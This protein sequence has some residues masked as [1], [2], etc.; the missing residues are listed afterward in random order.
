ME[1]REVLFTCPL[2]KRQGRVLVVLPLKRFSIPHLDLLFSRCPFCQRRI[3]ETRV[4]VMVS[5]QPLS[6]LEDFSLAPLERVVTELFGSS[7]DGQLP[8]TDAEVSAF[9]QS[10]PW[11]LFHA[12]TARELGL[13]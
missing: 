10:A 3:P 4:K 2:C 1:E 9:G 12:P 7:P 11:L 8:M 5:Q 13:G 6:P